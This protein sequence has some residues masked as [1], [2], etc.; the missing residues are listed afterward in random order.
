MQSRYRLKKP[1]FQWA[2]KFVWRMG[3]T[4]TTYQETIWFKNNYISTPFDSIL[5]SGRSHLWRS[6][7]SGNWTLQKNLG[8]KYEYVLATHIDKD[9]IHN[10]IIF[11]SIGVDE[12]EV[13]HFYYGS[14]MNI[15]NQS[16][17]FS[18]EHNLSII[19]LKKCK[20]KVEQRVW[21]LGDETYS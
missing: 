3:I 13:Y 15:R 7:S 12:G 20:S 17:K 5:C 2:V 11:N 9:Y 10:H 21:T 16:D 8:G 18:K 14:Y 6:T 4:E 19:D 1:Y